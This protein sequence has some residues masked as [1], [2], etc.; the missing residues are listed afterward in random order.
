MSG[1]SK[2]ENSTSWQTGKESTGPWIW[3]QFPLIN[4]FNRAEGAY[5]DT[6]KN[7]PYQGDYVAQGDAKNEAA[8]NQAYQFGMDPKNNAYID[9]LFS[10]ANGW[11]DEGSGYTTRGAAGLESLS[12]D[13]TQ[14]IIDQGSQYANNPY[15][16]E[17]V[18]SAMIDANRN[19]AES[20]VPNLYR[21]AASGNTLMS[22]RAALAQGVVERGLAERA[23]GLSG[24]MRY[25]ALNSG[26][27]RAVQELNNRRSTYGTMADLGTRVSSQGMT[28][29]N[30][31]IQDKGSL[32]QM[33]AAGAEG[34]R[35]LRQLALDNA[36]AKYEGKQNF[37]WAALQNFYSI[38]GGNNWGGERSYSGIGGE[39]KTVK[40]NPSLMSTIGS[41]LGAVGSLFSGGTNSGA[42][43]LFSFLGGRR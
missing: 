13:Q 5:Q 10:R 38:I 17:A 22:D 26:L 9:N 24:E 3:Q 21:S 27:D 37:P 2:T 34:L 23:L 36:M 6:L 28:G 39:S 30:E 18:K 41:G 4:A 29:L 40:D 20:A 25:N 11:L 15:I 33:S 7:G 35:G 32:N 8:L 42:S 1:G 14:K 43:G 19:A 31:A 12:G 16:S